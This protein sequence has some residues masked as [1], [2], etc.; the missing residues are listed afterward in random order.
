MRNRTIAATFALALVATAAQAHVTIR[1]R[2][3]NAGATE[4]YTVRVP[5]EGK[6]ATASVELEIPDDVTVVSVEGTPETREVKRR[7]NRVVTI[8][9]N[10]MI[11]PGD[12]REF[13]FV[14]KNPSTASEVA[15]R[16]HQRYAD[17]T[18]A[19]WTEPAG[20]RRPGPVTKLIAAGQP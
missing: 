1:P 3:S 6:V 16:V 13:T 4:T 9:W 20:S 5:T 17:G 11:P 14:A 2:E 10:V 7:G 19:D 18:S 12:S 15:W 8:T